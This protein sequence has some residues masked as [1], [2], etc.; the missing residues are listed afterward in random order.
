MAEGPMILDQQLPEYDVVISVH[1]VVAAD[2]QTAWQAA[3]DLDFMTVRTPLVTASTWVRGLPDRLRGTAAPKPREMRL[4]DIGG[5][6]GWL[7]LGEAE[8]EEIAFGAVGQF[9]QGR[10]SWHELPREAFASFNEPG[11]GKIGCNFTTRPYGEGRTLVSYECRT[12]ITDPVSRRKFARYWRVISPFVSHIMRA[13]IA[14][15]AADAERRA[16]GRRPVPVG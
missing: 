16:A 7:M 8:G 15:I 11:Y 1:R 13:T 12:A 2:P 10:I 9:W 5:T 14:V 4:A 3:R 6:P